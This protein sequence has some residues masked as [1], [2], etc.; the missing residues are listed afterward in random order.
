M[1]LSWLL[2]RDSSSLSAWYARLTH[3]RPASR[4]AVISVSLR[5]EQEN[6]GAIRVLHGPVDAVFVVLLRRHLL[7]FPREVRS[8][9]TSLSSANHPTLGSAHYSSEC[10]Q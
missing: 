8:I 4:L 5:I 9:E 3:L 1:N 10:A 7:D 6:A 2:V